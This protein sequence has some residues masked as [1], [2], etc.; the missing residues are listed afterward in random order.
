MKVSTAVYGVQLND[1]KRDG[2][3][4]S[5]IFQV[6]KE[7]ALDTLT[8]PEFMGPC[9]KAVLVFDCAQGGSVYAGA[10]LPTDF[11]LDTGDLKA[12]KAIVDAWWAQSEEANEIKQALDLPP[13]LAPKFN[14]TRD[15]TPAFT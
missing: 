3:T 9:D 6:L 8:L 12:I 15:E 5:E 14:L 1:I 11:S 13:Q 7:R 2:C 4:A 10:M